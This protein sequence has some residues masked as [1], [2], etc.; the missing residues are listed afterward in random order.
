VQIKDH[1]SWTLSKPRNRNCRKSRPRLIWPK[2]AP[3]SR[4]AT[5]SVPTPPGLQLAPHPVSDRQMPGHLHQVP[6]RSHRH[7]RR[8]RGREGP[9]PDVAGVRRM[10]AQHHQSEDRRRAEKSQSTRPDTRTEICPQSVPAGRGTSYEINDTVTLPRNR[11]LGQAKGKF[12]L[13]HRTQVYP[14]P[15]A[16]IR[17]DGTAPFVR[18]LTG[19]RHC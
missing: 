14:C 9:T 16:V 5:R 15:N 2:P 1:S 3:R 18:E 4:C 12:I 8:Q 11:S 13:A 17:P 19:H 10:A 7:I 6:A